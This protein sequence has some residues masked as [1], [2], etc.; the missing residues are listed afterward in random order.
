MK[1]YLKP[2]MHTVE[3]SEEEVFTLNSSAETVEPEEENEL[4]IVPFN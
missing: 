4:P 1:E 3:F 2:L